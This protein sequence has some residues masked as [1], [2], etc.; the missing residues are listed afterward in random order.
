MLN[1]RSKR[2]D[3]VFFKKKTIK[4]ILF[5]AN[6][7]K[8]VSIKARSNFKKK[9]MLKKRLKLGIY[10]NKFIRKTFYNT[11]TCIP[12]IL[13]YNNLILYKYFISR[14]LTI[15]PKMRGFK[16]GEFII[17]RKPFNFVAKT[18]KKKDLRR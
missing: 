7:L 14:K 16:I 11:S 1:R 2:E 9:K 12:K 3:F 4:N 6:L 8:K 13:F 15:L 17:H 18:K 10:L 5:R